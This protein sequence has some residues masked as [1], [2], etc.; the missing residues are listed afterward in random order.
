VPCFPAAR[1][2][3]FTG[4]REGDAP[5]CPGVG[6]KYAI[7]ANMCSGPK[8]VMRIKGVRVIPNQGTTKD[9]SNL[10][11]VCLLCVCVCVCSCVRAC[12]RACA[13]A[14]ACVCEVDVHS[15]VAVYILTH[16]WAEGHTFM[17]T[18]THTHTHTHAHTHTGGGCWTAARCP[19]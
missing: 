12:G 7:P 16:M 19:G 4:T 11:A 3:I 17:P 14:C 1:V 6:N 9:K 18:R 5:Q 15:C 13:C 10:L 2:T 8:S